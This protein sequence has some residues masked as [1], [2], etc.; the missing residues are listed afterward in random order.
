MHRSGSILLVDGDVARAERLAERLDHF[1]FAIQIAANG[2]LGLLTAHA[3][4]PK[5]VV[6]AAEMPVLDGYRMVDALRSTSETREIPV[7][8]LTE[9]SGPEELA[10]GWHVGADLCIPR[11]QGEAHVL[12]TL[13]RVLSSIGSGRQPVWAVSRG[14]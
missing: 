4:R 7:V 6:A 10:R 1:D 14:F 13:H 3:E 2:A 9:G 8:L 12:A 11:D 5:A